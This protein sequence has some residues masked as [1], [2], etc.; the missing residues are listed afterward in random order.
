LWQPRFWEHAIRDERDLADHLDY[1]HFNLVRHGYA[2]EPSEWPWSSFR[3]HVR[4]G[5]YPAAWAAEP[6]L[7][8]LHD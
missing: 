6:D 3:R 4:S 5:R 1:V 2:T 7:A 8:V